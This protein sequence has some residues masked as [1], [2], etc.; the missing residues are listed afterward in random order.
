MKRIK[1]EGIT[2]YVNGKG[3][4]FSE[5]GVKKKSYLDK[6]GYERVGVW[7]PSEKKTVVVRVHTLMGIAFFDEEYVKKGLV[8]NHKDLDKS[9]NS[10]HNLELVTESDNA[11]HAV[12]N[13]TCKKMVFRGVVGINDNHSIFAW[14]LRELENLGFDRKRVAKAVVSGVEYKNFRWYKLEDFKDVAHD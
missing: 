9:N 1:Y 13:G 5:Q 14:R 4:V 11:I 7:I 10:L 3:E 8:I 2:L 6:Q 12:I